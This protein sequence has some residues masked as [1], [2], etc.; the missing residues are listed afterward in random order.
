MSASVDNTISHRPFVS[1]ADADPAGACGVS[2]IIPAHNATATLEATLNSLVHQTRGVWEAIIIDDGSGDSTRAVAEHWAQRD[3]RFRVL[4]QERLGVSAAR[5]R[6][7]RDARHPFVLFLDSDDRIAS[8]HLER[9]V[10]MLAADSTLDAVHCGSQRILPS[11]V[12][13]RPRLGSDEADLFQ[14]FA[15]QCYF[16][17]HACVLRRDLALAVGGFE[18]S[19]TTCEDWDFF[20]RVARTGARFGRVP[21]VLAYYHVRAD[22]ASHDIQR[23]VSDAR[24][25]LDRGHGRDPR[26]QI[27][28]EV[29]AEGRAPAYRNLSLYCLLTAFAAQKI[30]AGHDALDLLDAGDLPPAPDLS[31][32]MVADTIH[33]FLPMAAGRSEQDW[34]A[35]WSCVSAS[36]AAFLTKLEAHARAPRLA[37]VALRH[38]EKKILLADPTRDSL[39][40]GSTYRVDV[41]LSKPV[42]DVFLPSEADRLICRLTL[43]GE[44]IGVVELPGVGALAGQRIAEAAFAGPG[45][46][47]FRRALTPERSV[48]L[49][50]R[51]VRG[52]LRPR[53]L[54]LVYCVMAAK[55]K[56]RLDAA[57]R[58]KHEVVSVA[59]ANLPRVITPRPGVAARQADHE[60]RKSVDAAAAAGRARARE[61]VSPTKSPDWWD[62]FFVSP[63]PW[64]YES[65]YEAVKYEQ[66]LALLPKEVVTDALE[67]ACAEGHFTARL[68]PR[69][70][71]LTAVDISARALAR[72]QARCS[73]HGN[74]AFQRLDLN[75]DDIPGPFDLIVC[76]EVLYFVRDLA[77]V[78]GR[79]LAQ[80]RPGGFFLTA[81]S[82]V[83]I[84][85]PEG[86]GFAWN[87]ACGIETVAK[88]ITAQP[89]IALHRE[90]R[91]PLYRILLYQRLVP[92]QPP[93][94]PESVESDRMGQM[95]PAARDFARWPGRS[96]ARVA[97][98]RTGSVPILM[99]HRIAADG[100]AALAR[101]RVTPDLF[102]AQIAT[103]H[104]A[105][106]RTI[107]FQDWISAM[108]RNEPLPGKPI[109]LTFD[110]G[111][112][113]FLTAAM[114]VLRYYGFSATVFLVAERIGGVADWDAGY[115]EAVP[116][117][118][119]Q[120]VRALQA[121][122]IE[123]G[124]HSAMHWPMTGMHLT[125]L[126]E[127][128]ARARAILEEGLE[129]SVTT[130]AY[131]YG[132]ENEFVRRVVADLGFRAAASCEPGISRLGDDPLRLRRIEIFGGCAPQQ[133]LTLIG[134]TSENDLSDALPAQ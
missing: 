89:G 74:V 7:L 82:R 99:Y 100:P 35:I 56:D 47:L 19:L 44:P 50:L 104:R 73:G 5:N 18:T 21:E 126:T 40:L 53:I 65:D 128:T 79:I 81:H 77:G 93:G 91:T 118:S 122:A 46:L 34:P 120:E 49:G 71:R 51:V 4:H 30:G 59:K 62:R 103:L 28:A 101:F 22:S 16:P 66:T 25:V 116:L 132:A 14:Y 129:A 83:L 36:V 27:A 2:V 106:Y 72:A 26:M 43:R 125:E 11:G 78:V 109:I 23:C 75:V 38:S 55:P 39:L 20:Q 67:I 58:L 12:A 1:L 127:D 6:G 8:T 115:G 15:F 61:Q 96:P 117:L 98:E 90:L 113:D 134:H 84:D 110:D 45:R 107:G 114:P 80:I 24:L 123:F 64:A 69:V 13:G 17:I 112:Q 54:R 42:R 94:S 133:L 57:R 86:I 97:P 121:T 31:A 33:E 52:L 85:D 76:S 63:D 108:I 48:H 41:N 102:A 111:Y 92:G 105:G 68:A 9:M 29:H 124:C 10:G 88:T 60:W 87:Q 32:A 37:F 131:P 70:G 119:W 130:L 95:I 3:R